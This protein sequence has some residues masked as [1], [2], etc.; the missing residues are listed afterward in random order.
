MALRSVLM[1]MNEELNP[2]GTRVQ[3]LCALF[4]QGDDGIPG[5]PGLSGP[6]VSVCS[7]SI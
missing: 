7:M 6:K 5:E 4:H 3:A 2:D 1:G